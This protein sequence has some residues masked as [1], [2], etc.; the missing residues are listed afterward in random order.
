[1]RGASNTNNEMKKILVIDDDQAI[2]QLITHYLKK[3]GYQLLAAENG[4]NGV[5]FAIEAKPDLIFLD[6]EMP[7]K[8]NGLGALE[9]IKANSNTE[10]IPIIMLTVRNDPFSVKKAMGLGADDYIVK[11]FKTGTLIGKLEILLSRKVEKSW[12]ALKPIQEKI[13]QVTL[14]G[15]NGINDWAYSKGYDPPFQGIK[16]V[17]AVIIEGIEAGE[18]DG[19]LEAVRDHSSET[20]AHLI[21]VSIYLA[22][23]ARYLNQSQ[24]HSFTAGEMEDFVVGGLLHDIGNIDVPLEILYK[25][26]GFSEEEQKEMRKHVEHIENILNRIP[27][28]RK[29]PF[30]IATRHHERWGGKGYP[31][32]MQNDGI[33]I[34]GMMAAIVDVFEAL[35]AVKSYKKGMSVEKALQEM[36]KFNGYFDKKLL[37]HF[38]DVILK[39][40]KEKEEK[41][42]V[43]VAEVA[44][45]EKKEKE[46]E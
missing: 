28:V 8:M 35:T 34:P 22:I 41:E 39:K 44:K 40:D 38:K 24:I 10:D 4:E 7:G 12:Q 11:P 19:V 21:R 13:L 31:K 1:M 45:K 9:V 37:K 16:D 26:E 17:G 29:I 27:G 32:G 46:N 25:P 20:F 2:H 18:I 15:I 3:M 14:N 23:F 6:I 43:A 36:S 33:G 30:E 42:V 5:S